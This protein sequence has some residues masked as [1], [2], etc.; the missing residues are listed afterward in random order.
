MRKMI[1]II[2]PRGCRLTV[3]SQNNVT[4]N[5]CIRGKDYALKE[6][7]NPERALTSFIKVNNR[8]N[9]VISVKTS[10]PIPKDKIFLVM[11]IIK[12]KS[13]IAPIKI[14]EIIIKN[15]LNLG[16]DIIS[17]KEIL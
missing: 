8:L 14:G 2:C 3:D 11:E 6:I 9:T 4:G 1:C 12:Q 13:V 17:T 5:F 15:V 7:N 10:G 16:V